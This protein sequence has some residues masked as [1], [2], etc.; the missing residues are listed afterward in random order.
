[1]EKHMIESYLNE[2][3][4]E[5][6]EGRFISAHNNLKF[7]LKNI[8]NQDEYGSKDYASQGNHAVGGGK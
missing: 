8:Y 3:E 4:K 2:I 1:M 5:M 6:S 7:V